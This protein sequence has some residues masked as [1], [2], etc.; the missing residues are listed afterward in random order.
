[1]FRACL[2]SS[3]VVPTTWRYSL[4]CIVAKKMRVVLLLGSWSG[5]LSAIMSR[6]V[7]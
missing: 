5:A 4:F 3:A 2:I 7:R 6:K 1:M